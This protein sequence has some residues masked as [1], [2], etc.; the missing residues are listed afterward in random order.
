M[1]VTN[2]DVKYVQHTT[3]LIIVNDLS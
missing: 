2:A 1:V 3:H